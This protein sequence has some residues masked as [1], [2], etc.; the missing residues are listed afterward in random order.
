MDKM[1]ELQGSGRRR[2]AGAAAPMPLPAALLAALL[3]AVLALPLPAWAQRARLTHAE[4]PAKL[5]RKNQ[6][7]EAPAG[8]ALYPGDLVEA[9]AHAVQIEWPSGVMLALGPGSSLVVDDALAFPAVTLLRGWLKVAGA[10]SAANARMNVAAGPLKVEASGGGVIHV[11]PGKAELFVEQGTLQ[12]GVAD[13]NPPAAPLSLGHDQYALHS[14]P[15]GLQASP[16]PA[17]P[18]VNEMPRAFFDPLL[19]LAARTRPAEAVP[20]REANA[21][22]LARVN[23]LAGPQRKQMQTRLAPR[24]ATPPKKPQKTLPNTLF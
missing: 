3:G 11:V 19:A 18:F 24:P 13:A 12:V 6:V 16:R 15:Q 4:A 23:E 10:S 8:V 22:D 14:A 5:V 17:R 1:S 9:A 21:S 20:L 2:S 7:Y